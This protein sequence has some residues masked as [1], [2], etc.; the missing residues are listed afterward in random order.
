MGKGAFNGTDP[1]YTG[2]LGMHGTKTSNFAVIKLKPNQ[3]CDV[4]EID[5]AANE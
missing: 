2:M 4:Y 5:A 3:V 1:R